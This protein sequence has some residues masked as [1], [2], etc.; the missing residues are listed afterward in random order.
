MPLE[1]LPS[2]H[3]GFVCDEY[4]KITSTK[5]EQIS[6][7]TA[8]LRSGQLQEQAAQ[9]EH[10]YVQGLKPLMYRGNVTSKGSNVLRERELGQRRQKAL[11]IEDVRSAEMYLNA[12]HYDCD[13]MTHSEALSSN[14]AITEKLRNRE[15]LVLWITPAEWHYKHKRTRSSQHHEVDQAL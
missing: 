11:V 10:C 13:R 8:H 4:D 14:H 9:E 1:P 6:F 15:Y 2:G 5:S 7:V 3:L 12:R